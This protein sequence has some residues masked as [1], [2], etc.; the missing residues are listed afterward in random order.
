MQLRKVPIFVSMLTTIALLFGGWFLYQK[1]NVEEPIR[2]QVGQLAS[3]SLNELKVEKEQIEI[4]LT[5]KKPDTLPED[6]AKLMKTISKIAPGKH[7]D[8]TFTN[9][10]DQLKQVWAS[11]L[12]AFTE[13]LDLH[14]YSKIP[15]LI[16]EIKATNRLDF[17]QSHMDEER[18]YV[19]L[20]RG[21][22]EYFVI[23]PKVNDENEVT[24]RG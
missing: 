21:K 4:N 17:A 1:V 18:I 14:Q 8:I 23:V 11:G 20:K 19:Y 13:A 6:Y 5:V 10:D 22:S 3:F 24:A 16:E 2:T 15:A 9:Q 7:V 12:F